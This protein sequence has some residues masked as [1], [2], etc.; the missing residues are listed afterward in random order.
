[1]ERFLNAVKSHAAALDH[2]MGQ[3]RFGLVTS[4]DPQRYAARVALQPEGVITGWL[5]IATPWVGSGW[6][7]V[8]PPAPGDQVLVLPQE[9]NAE[10][11][12]IVGLSFSDRARP[13]QNAPAGEFWLVHRSGTS[14]KLANDGT[15]RIN[16]DLHVA[17]DVYD[18][19]G[20]LSRLRGHY[21][22]HT[23]PGSASTQPSPQD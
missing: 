1:M 11:G 16:G 5:P 4:V 17:G 3:P 18:S 8:C 14:L 23:H 21:D 6:G 9:G 15:V 13:P 12:V 10:H 22:Q 20:S 2:G 19:A 7:L